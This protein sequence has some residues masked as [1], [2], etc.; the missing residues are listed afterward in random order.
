MKEEVRSSVASGKVASILYD[1]KG[2]KY[3]LL[4]DDKK[5]IK[6]V[7]IHP[8][9]TRIRLE[10]LAV[11]RETPRREISTAEKSVKEIT[12]DIGKM[13][14]DVRSRPIVG[15]LAESQ[16]AFVDD[17]E[18]GAKATDPKEQLISTYKGLNTKAK[19]LED[20]ITKKEA[21]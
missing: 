11:S 7:V 19:L 5:T 21:A 3:S 17:L 2:E 6:E 15:D 1:G 8:P 13:N 16:S 12:K 9:I 4:Y 20:L 18:Q 10:T 14:A